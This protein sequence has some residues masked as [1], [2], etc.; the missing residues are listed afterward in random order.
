MQAT[1]LVIIFALP[2]TMRGFSIRLRYLG[3]FDI[4]VDH[5]IVKNL[6]YPALLSITL[7]S[8]MSHLKETIAVGWEVGH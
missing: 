3:M 4:P 7:M 6:L 8:R 2:C 5:S 1:K